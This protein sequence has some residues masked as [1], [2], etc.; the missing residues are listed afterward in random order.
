[1]NKDLTS[2]I[3]CTPT[4]LTGKQPRTSERRQLIALQV[5]QALMTQK[6]QG[7]IVNCCRAINTVCRTKGCRF[8][9]FNRQLSSFPFLLGIQTP[10]QTTWFNGRPPKSLKKERATASYC[11]NI[12]HVSHGAL[13]QAPNSYIRGKSTYHHALRDTCPVPLLVACDTF[14]PLVSD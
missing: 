8:P 2:H 6:P 10:S 12:A 1:M 3:I 13:L 11:T 9:L 5:S 4:A 14:L 7:C